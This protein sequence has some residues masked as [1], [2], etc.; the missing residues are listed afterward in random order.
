[1]KNN[2]NIHKNSNISRVNDW[3]NSNTA[4]CSKLSVFCE[5]SLSVLRL[6]DWRNKTETVHERKDR[7]NKLWHTCTV[8][9]TDLPESHGEERAVMPRDESPVRLCAVT[10]RRAGWQGQ[11]Q[12]CQPIASRAPT[13][14]FT[15]NA[16]RRFCHTLAASRGTVADR[17]LRMRSW[18]EA[19][20]AA[21]AAA[22][23][24][25]QGV[26]HCNDDSGKARAASIRRLR[27]RRTSGTKSADCRAL[28]KCNRRWRLTFVAMLP[29]D[30]RTSC[31][32]S[33]SQW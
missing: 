20:T 8:D 18:Q 12:W 7:S 16:G 19:L 23:A 26:R 2:K 30:W 13:R 15:H 17:Q 14:A 9:W 21:A 6:R 27:H 28:W 24:A 5:T 3:N 4:L 22:A 11:P 25:T 31:R 1:M 32:H 10:D 33:S 29:C